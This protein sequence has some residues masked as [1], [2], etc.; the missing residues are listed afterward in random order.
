[1]FIPQVAFQGT[2]VTIENFLSWK[3]RFELEMAELRRKRQKE[4]EQSGKS[5]LT[6]KLRHPGSEL[7]KKGIIGCAVLCIKKNF[8]SFVFEQNRKN[9]WGAGRWVAFRYFY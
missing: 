2:V 4:E 3:A 8:K 1:M 6:G 5:K 7:H 9:N